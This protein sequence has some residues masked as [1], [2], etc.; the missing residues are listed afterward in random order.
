MTTL[1]D[2]AWLLNLRG[3][4]INFNPL[5]FS[6]MLFNKRDGNHSVDLFV[7]E[8]KLTDLTEY[9]KQINV[10]VHSYDTIKPFIAGMDKA[11]VMIDPTKCN[12]MLYYALKEAGQKVQLS[13]HN[14]IQLMK[15]KKN[16]VLQEGMR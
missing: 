14:I 11:N 4:D 9:L 2:I 1:D 16:P 3:S 15:A 7:D 8:N 13:D 12:I 5:F 10:T 6:Y